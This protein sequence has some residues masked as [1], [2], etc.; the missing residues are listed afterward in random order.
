[1]R[2]W[3]PLLLAPIL[4]LA[5]QSVAYALAGWACAHQQPAAMHGVHAVTFIACAGG[6]FAAWGLWR[7]SAGPGDERRHVRH[8]LSGIAIASSALAAAAIAAM[9]M[10]NA[11]LPPCFG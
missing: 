9:W 7:E 5:D 3:F 6:A 8:F 11:I 2:I 1:M 10:A 4:A